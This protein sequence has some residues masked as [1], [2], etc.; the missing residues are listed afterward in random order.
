M[1]NSC[2][3]GGGSGRSN[4]V[5]MGVCVYVCAR[6]GARACTS[7]RSRIR[8]YKCVFRGNNIQDRQR[9]S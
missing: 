4:G 2:G 7:A 6:A 8:M 5:C 1:L 3:D 9:K